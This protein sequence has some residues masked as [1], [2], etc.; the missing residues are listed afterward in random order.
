M[1]P[2]SFPTLRDNSPSKE[3]RGSAAGGRAEAQSAV[4]QGGGGTAAPFT[5]PSLGVTGTERKRAEREPGAA[6]AC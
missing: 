6:T 1:K 4:C 3:K 2:R 5:C